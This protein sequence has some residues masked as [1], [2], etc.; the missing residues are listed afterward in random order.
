MTAGARKTTMA[1]GDIDYDGK[2]MYFSH[3]TSERAFV[4]ASHFRALTATRS[5]TNAT[6]AQ[7]IFGAALNVAAATAYEIEMIAGISTT[8]A[9]SNALGLSFGGTA[10]LT[11]IG[12]LATTTNQATS[13]V[14]ISNAQQIYVQTAANVNVTAAVAAATFRNISVRGVIRVNAAGTLIPQCAY[15]AAP[16]AAPIV[17]INSYVK[18]TPIGTNTETSLGSWV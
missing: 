16:G 10:T 11:S 6:G 18:L 8:G 14:T 3:T 1:N 4:S 15:S 7:S 13:H 5:L 2:S 17:A 12:Y 9:T